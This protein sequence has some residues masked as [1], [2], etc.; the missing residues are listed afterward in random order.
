MVSG[1]GTALGWA[2]ENLVLSFAANRWLRYLIKGG[3]RLLFFWL[4][5]LDRLLVNQPGALD[6]ASCTYFYGRKINGTVPDR[7]VIEQYAGAK[8][9][10]HI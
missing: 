7:E 10:S 9:M 3:V 2:I 1:P 8:H 6:G 4:K 5:H